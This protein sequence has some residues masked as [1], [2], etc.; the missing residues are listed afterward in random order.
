MRDLMRLVPRAFHELGVVVS[1]SLTFVPQTLR[2]IERI[3]E[4]Q[5]VRGHR[6]K[7]LRD[8]VPIVTPL[9]ISALERG[10]TLAE[11][12]MARGYATVAASAAVPARVL[13]TA[14]LLASLGGWLALLLVP[15][16]ATLAVVAIALGVGML[17]GALWVTGRS[18]NHTSYRPSRWRARDSLI[19]GGCLPILIVLSTRRDILFYS[20]YPKLMLPIFDPI[21]GICALGLL[22]PGLLATSRDKSR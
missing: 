21:A 14:G 18:R 16:V 5:A 17:G 13:L 8:W 10:F 7:G 4:A 20:P 3:R 11:S 12:M 2:S 19:V 6:L 1:I 22:V 15:G 9:L